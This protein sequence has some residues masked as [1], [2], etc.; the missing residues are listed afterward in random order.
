MKGV[1]VALFVTLSVAYV[2]ARPNHT[3]SCGEVDLCMAPCVRYLTRKQKEPSGECCTGVK[4]LKGMPKN[5]QER[6]FACNCMKQAALVFSGLKDDAVANLSD[7]C[8]AP[9]LF[10]IDMNC[11]CNR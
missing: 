11:D 5:T 4:Q 3:L 7:A 9:L 8:H 6:R 1:F 2:V 10:P